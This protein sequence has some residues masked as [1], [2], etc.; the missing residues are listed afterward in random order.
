M[1]SFADLASL[2]PDANHVSKCLT[3]ILNNCIFENNQLRQEKTAWS[4]K[5]LIS[6][7]YCQINLL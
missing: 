6:K 3:D 4:Y 1:V 2:L 7:F 5:G